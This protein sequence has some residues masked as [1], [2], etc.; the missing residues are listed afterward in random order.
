[1]RSST[2]CFVLI[3]AVSVPFAGLAEAQSETEELQKEVDELKAQL[4][5]LEGKLDTMAAGEPVAGES[6][7]P[8][9]EDETPSEEKKGLADYVDLYGRLD[10]RTGVDTDGVFEI[11]DNVSY[12]GV[13][14]ELPLGSD[15]YSAFAQFEVGISMVS[16]ANQLIFSFNPLENQK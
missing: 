6:A 5:Q 1:M 8:Q 14:G 9:G 4:Q 16:S 11:N 10:V 15:R 7:E 3:L 12:L 13:T 2:L